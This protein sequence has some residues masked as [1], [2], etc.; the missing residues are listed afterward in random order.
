[1]KEN[2]EKNGLFIP[3]ID[4]EFNSELL[5]GITMSPTLNPDDTIQGILSLT[6]NKYHNITKDSIVPSEIPIRY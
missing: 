3:Y 1:M 4:I 2:L 6:K 5:V